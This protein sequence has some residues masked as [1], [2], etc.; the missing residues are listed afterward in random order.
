MESQ[1]Q[2]RKF[3]STGSSGWGY[4]AFLSSNAHDPGGSE[5]TGEGEGPNISRKVPELVVSWEM[6]CIL[7]PRLTQQVSPGMSGSSFEML[8]AS[9]RHTDKPPGLK[10]SHSSVTSSGHIHAG[11][12][13]RNTKRCRAMQV[14]A[15]LGRNR[16]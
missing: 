4:A 13:Y 9:V 2:V 7:P 15:F 11:L 8:C 5:E 10:K 12:I 6:C 1:R 14:T 16:K 3:K